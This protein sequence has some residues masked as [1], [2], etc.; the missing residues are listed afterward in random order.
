MKRKLNDAQVLEVYNAIGTGADLADAYGVS[1]TT[2]WR[3]KR[4]LTMS[5]ITGHKAGSF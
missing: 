3:I 4:G 1:E 5:H 2:I